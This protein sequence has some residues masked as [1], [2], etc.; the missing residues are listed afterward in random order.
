MR[1]RDIGIDRFRGA[2]HI[3]L[4]VDHFEALT[5]TSVIPIGL[6]YQSMGFV[7]AAE[8]FVF[9]S[10]LVSGAVYTRVSAEAGDRAMWCKALHRVRDI[11]LHYLFASVAFLAI[12]RSAGGFLHDWGSWNLLA[13]EPFL[14]SSLEIA[15]LLVRPTFLEVL[16]MYCF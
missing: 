12:V 7:S 9:I 2:L 10:G 11:Y 6:V 1:A 4:N 8:G 13:S 16:P 14:T 5:R 15:A 3:L